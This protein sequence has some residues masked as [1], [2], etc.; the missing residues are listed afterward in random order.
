MKTVLFH[1]GMP[2]C[3][4]TTIQD[5]LTKQGTWLE[6]RGFSYKKHPDDPTERQGNA[7]Q[8]ADYAMTGTPAQL[9]EHLDFFL[10]CDGD[11]VLSSEMLFVLGRG[12]G[13]E[14]IQQEVLHRGFDLRV[15]VYLKRQD[16]WIES[17]YKQHVKDAN[18]WDGTFADL[19]ALRRSKHT[20]DYRFLLTSWAKQVG[21]ARMRVVALNPSQDEDYAID[22]FLSLLGLPRPEAEIA[23]P[24]QNV[25][26]SASATEAARQIK[27][28]LIG[29][30]MAPDDIRNLIQRFLETVRD[31]SLDVPGDGFLSPVAR[32]AL[33]SEFAASNAE[34]SR[35]FLG[36]KP[37]FDDLPQDDMADW[38]PPTER[39][40][41]ILAGVI[42]KS[43]RQ[44]RQDDRS[45]VQS[46]APLTA[47]GQPEGAVP[48]LARMK[49][50]LHR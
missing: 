1:V 28:Q 19:L 48:L 23:A 32:R 25:S 36:G 31:V 4:T 18:L 38:V 35:S 26:P 8:L 29:A 40:P 3:A 41:A 9:L 42:A 39:V 33:L 21:H 37:A 2:K 47:S 11:V 20:L 5:F 13:F 46:D 12:N 44:E 6:E 49:S 16:L 22:S 7:A 15:I 10:N 17:D 45:P 14:T 24:R 27:L 50:L 34:L 30:G 43:L